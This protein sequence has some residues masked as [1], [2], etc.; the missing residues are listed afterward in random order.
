[1]GFQHPQDMGFCSAMVLAAPS[2]VTGMRPIGP[3]GCDQTRS[4]AFVAFEEGTMGWDHH[5]IS[6]GI[7]IPR[8]WGCILIKGFGCDF[9]CD[10][11]GPLGPGWVWIGTNQV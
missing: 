2:D 11:R 8:L 10:W 4:K 3:V 1:M 6:E 9:G 7:H 5:V